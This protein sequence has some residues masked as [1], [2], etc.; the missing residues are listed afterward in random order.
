M[1]VCGVDWDEGL[2]MPG[3]ASVY[4]LH[5]TLA[6]EIRKVLSQPITPAQAIF[7]EGLQCKRTC[8]TALSLCAA[9]AEGLK[10]NRHDGE[11][12]HN[13][14]PAVQPPLL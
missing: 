5:S 2:T 7:V 11:S 13:L 4:V 1:D 6:E 8:Q 3:P 9:I 14:L 12:T 10:E